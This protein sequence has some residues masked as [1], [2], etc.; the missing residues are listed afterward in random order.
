MYVNLR[1]TI[2]QVFLQQSAKLV[3]V[4][5][6]FTLVTTLWSLHTL[7]VI[8]MIWARYFTHTPA[9]SIHKPMPRFWCYP[10]T[11]THN[12]CSLSICLTKSGI[13]PIPTWLSSRPRLPSLD[14]VLPQHWPT[15]TGTTPI[16][17]CPRLTS[18]QLTWQGL[19][20]WEAGTA[21][22]HD[23]LPIPAYMGCYSGVFV[24]FLWGNRGM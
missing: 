11:P 12:R 16:P 21:S 3:L 7:L 24:W 2:T 15:K 14:P 19:S 8:S 4:M 5:T 6:L 1:G 10:S 18:L 9:Q 13:T 22:P 20:W 17:S 23:R